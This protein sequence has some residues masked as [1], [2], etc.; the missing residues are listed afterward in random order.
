MTKPVIDNPAVTNHRE[1]FVAI[2]TSVG[3]VVEDNG[4]VYTNCGVDRH[5]QVT[6]PA[7]NVSDDQLDR[8]M[9]FYH[10]SLPRTIGVWKED[11]V[12][13]EAL[14]ARLIARG[15]QI[16]WEPKWMVLDLETADIRPKHIKD[17][18]I[19][20]NNLAVIPSSI[21]F[22][23][24]DD[25]G[26]Y[27]VDMRRSGVITKFV[28]THKGS[29]IGHCDLFMGTE[30][31]IHNI[32]VHDSHTG[33]GL[34]GQLVKNAC[35]FAQKKGYGRV[36]LNAI[37]QDLYLK[38]GFKHITNGSTWWLYREE[39]EKC[40]N[41]LAEQKI[42]QHVCLGELHEMDKLPAGTSYSF[43]TTSGMSLLQMAVKFN[44]T[45]MAQWL[46]AKGAPHTVLDL[47]DIGGASMASSMLPTHIDDLIEGKTALHHAVERG[48]VE[49]AKHLLVFN[50]NLDIRDSTY[51]CTALGWCSVLEQKEI[52]TLIRE[53]VEKIENT[54]FSSVSTNM[55]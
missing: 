5:A 6:F 35:V 29:I 21:P 55:L 24:K 4:L 25:D 2:A 9:D 13:N 52:G 19:K 10:S 30:A 36:S 27:S 50:P 48:N 40:Q 49:L 31:G 12:G 11:G 41:S 26:M 53:A 17:V 39:F 23:N 14:S 42:I 45:K 38:L 44:H 33:K 7:S 37:S 20:V 32:G 47:W 16:G 1:L 28:A 18:Y 43:P 51:S 34:G 15:F 22:S 54:E 46:I 3:K 8:M